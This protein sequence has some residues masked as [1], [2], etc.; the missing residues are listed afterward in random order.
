MT[1]AWASMNGGGRALPI[2]IAKEDLLIVFGNLYPPGNPCSR[3]CLSHRN[4]AML[5][6]VKEPTFGGIEASARDSRRYFVPSHSAI[7]VFEAVAALMAIE[8]IFEREIFATTAVFRNA[9]NQLHNLWRAPL[10]QIMNRVATL[11]RSRK[12]RRWRL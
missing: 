7:Y 1:L 10:L 5:V 6:R 4:R 12:V 2:I 3:A 8:L 9:L 11:S